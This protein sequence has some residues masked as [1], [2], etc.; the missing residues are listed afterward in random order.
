VRASGG[1]AEQVTRNG[2]A[3][4]YPS[5]DGTQIY[6]TKHDGDAELWTARV[7]GGEEHL[8]LPSVVNRAFVVLADGIYF[9]PRSSPNGHFG[10]YYLALFTRAVRLVTSI[11]GPP[12]HGTH[13]LA[14]PPARPVRPERSRGERSRAGEGVPVTLQTGLRA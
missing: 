11:N 8:V 6:Y 9:I 3:C 2:G 5:P 12:Q 10:V 1:Q 14:G 4:V 7:A 13:R